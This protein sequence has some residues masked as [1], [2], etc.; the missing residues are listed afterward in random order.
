MKRLMVLLAVTVLIAVPAW[1]QKA[2]T[3]IPI[4]KVVLFSSGVGYFEHVGLVEGD[5]TTT[6]MFKTE[7][8][9]DVLKSMVLMDLDDGTVSSV[10]Y[11]SRDP[12][13]RAL[14]SFGVDI[15]GDPALGDLLKQLRGA[16][17]DVMCPEK[18]SG[19]ILGIEKVQRK[20]SADGTTTILTEVVLNLVTPGGIKTVPMSTI[21]S[22]RF[23][24][25]KL[26]AELDKALALLIDSRDKDRKPVEVHFRGK[27][28][29]RIRIGYIAETPVWKTSYRLDLSGEKP[30]LQ[31]WAIVENTSD[32]DWSKVNLSLVSGRPISF[33][34]DLYT[35]LYMPRPVVVPELYASLRPQRYEE[36]IG[37]D[38]RAAP[39]MD[40]AKRLAEQR[41]YARKPMARAADRAAAPGVA[42]GR[43]RLGYAADAA[44]GH[45]SLAQ[46]V[47]SL[48]SAEKVGEL[49]HFPIKE[50]V[51]LPRRRSAMLPVVNTA[52]HAE[53]VS[54]YNAAVMPK[55]PLNGA[56]LVND[57]GMKLMGGPVTV[58]DGGMYAGDAQIDNLAE[59]DKRLLSYAIDLNV[60]VDPSAKSSAR[61]TSAKIVNGA[62]QLQRLNVY[63]QTYTIHNKADQERAVV[64]EHPFHAGRK[65]VEPDKYMDKTASLYRFRVPVPKEST[66]A[67]LVKEEHVRSETIAIL[68]QSAG[69]LL[70]Y[71][72]SG[73]IPQ[74]VKDALTKAIALKNDLSEMQAKLQSLEGQK[75][76][77]ETGQDRLRRNIAT[78]GR[79]SSLGKRYLTKLSEEE[80]QIEKLETDIKVLRAKIDDKQKE[81]ASYLRSLNVD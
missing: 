71:T 62:L 47:R 66:K 76:A 24:D 11:A 40:Q 75:R 9:N 35:P 15:S 74:K 33:I 1:G 4:T 22:L 43:Y 48:A 58:F 78:V 2:E 42:A 10:N 72:R 52:V 57:T 81:L 41:Q 59:A 13:L 5:A 7:Q 17:V 8:I 23:A 6:L 56:H 20:V 80:D 36:G 18:V 49:F 19:K 73:E 64:V 45:V 51:D 28:K 67:F 21:Q 46:G 68:T 27:G 14:K 65:L 63:E 29:R 54:I 69:S 25:A 77:I 55:H 53:K 60:T 12:I 32:V 79:D 37:A 16:Q 70:W 3:E 38:G 34:Q 39:A 44:K 31:G 30:I 26:Q 61:I 50:P